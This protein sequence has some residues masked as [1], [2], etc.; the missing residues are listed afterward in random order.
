[1][2]IK[3]DNLAN[4][5]F[6][7]V[8]LAF[9]GGIILAR[10][11]F[12]SVSVW[13]GLAAIGLLVG[14]FWRFFDKNGPILLALL[15]FFLFFGGA[16]YQF[17]QPSLTPEFL[18]Y[19]NDFPRTVWVTGTLE[20]PPDLRD[21]YQNLQVK[22][23]AVDFGDGDI[24]ISGRLLIRARQAQDLHYGDLIRAR[25]DIT[26]PAENEVF[27]YRDYLAQ[28][29]IHSS[30]SAARVTLLPQPGQKN[31]AWAFLYRIKASLSNRIYLL[32]PDPEASLLHGIL[33]GDDDGMSP[34]LQQA[35]KNT[36]TS[37]II[38]ISGFNIAII[39]AI[40]L[41]FFSRIFGKRIGALFAILGIVAY[42]LLVGAEA[43][44]VRAAFMG[45]LSI[46]AMQLGRRNLTLN[47]LA[48]TAV[49]MALWNPLVLGDVGFQLSFAATLG[50][51]LYT[52]P[53]QDATARRLRRFLPASLV[54]NLIG[55]LSNYFLMTLAA[56]IT[57]LPVIAYHFG[58]ISIASLFV[59]PLILPA[60][61]PLMIVGGL[62][63]L[64]SHLY[65]P[66]GKVLAAIAWPFAA[67]SIRVVELF[68]K[69]PNAAILTGEFSLLLLIGF[70]GLLFAATFSPQPL[71]TKLQQA[72][73]PAAVL[74]GLTIA[75]FLVL[76]LTLSAPDGRLHLTFLNVGSG[77][78]ILIQT[79]GGRQVLINGGPSPSRLSDQLGRRLPPFN[80]SLDYLVIAAPRENQVAALPTVIERF[81]PREI[82]WSGDIQGSYA[83]QKVNKWTLQNG[84]TASQ[85]EI[86][87]QLDLGDGAVLRV[88]DISP[89]GMVLLVEW[90]IFRVLLPIGVDFESFE[91][92]NYGSKIGPL[93]ALLLSESGYA[94][95]NPPEWLFNLSPKI[96]I[97][98]VAGDDPYG[99]PPRETLDQLQN[100]TLLRT[101]QNGWIKLSTNGD[102]L[103]VEVE[104]E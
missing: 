36:G 11:V 21:S 69:L 61:P 35:F 92:M 62:A 42:T 19:Y 41:A 8:A 28:H 45:T 58:R 80:R 14:I 33:L 63:V 46:L 84:T 20:S 94:Q 91:R 101:D 72:L 47:A 22:V 96:F 85:A 53:L 34:D 98:S 87:S 77:D 89:R 12:L 90:K 44:V 16:R 79:P 23:H 67:Y 83:A 81:P 82:L 86:G 3:L 88:V 7:W 5:H 54:E 24:A 66:L 70:Y 51:V 17:A 74:M 59:N 103:W 48:F 55:P 13:L 78:A 68:D 29:G 37:H 32:F 104:R 60:Q 38:A 4:L 31:I 71:K 49:V 64:A 2:K 75:L 56:Q 10:Q 93:T 65:L 99:L 100:Q 6:L 97:L 9:L 25:G 1:M 39:V 40:F 30:M 18:I 102:Q 15:P 43:S 76:R 57:A 95:A 73:K 26:T 27:S 52:Q 50:I